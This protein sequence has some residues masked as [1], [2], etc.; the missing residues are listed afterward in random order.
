MVSKPAT[1]ATPNDTSAYNQASKRMIK[2][3]EVALFSVKDLVK[4]IED[5]KDDVDLRHGVS[6]LDTKLALLLNYCKRLVFYI[7]ARVQS[8]DVQEHGVIR[9]LLNLLLLIKNSRPIEKKLRYTIDKT[10]RT[11]TLSKSD[12]LSH[13][14]RPNDLIIEEDSD[15]ENANQKDDVKIYKPPMLNPVFYTD[16]AAKAAIER[17]KE[18]LEKKLKQ[19]E[20]L[21][22]L[23]GTGDRPEEHKMGMQRHRQT[24]EDKERD[25]YELKYYKRIKTNKKER[26][27]LE[28]KRNAITDLADLS[29][30]D[31]DIKTLNALDALNQGEFGN[32]RKRSSSKGWKKN[33]K[34]KKKR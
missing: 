3:L 14:P 8:Y 10:T 5:K 29:G 27:R 17:R 2:N 23:R 28:N 7:M 32:K 21:D 1:S 4:K 16:D 33:K 11:T 18:F 24:D 25:E 22:V 6:F 15:I 9:Q 30:L 20:L 26:K 12:P 34:K 13:K 19:S 31:K